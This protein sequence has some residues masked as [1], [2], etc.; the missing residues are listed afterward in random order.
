MQQGNHTEL[1]R[2]SAARA[3]GLRASQRLLAHGVLGLCSRL[4][5]MAQIRNGDA[6]TD[7]M[8]ELMSQRR[9]MLHEL[10]MGIRNAAE[11]SCVAALSDA[12]AESDRG[13]LVMMSTAAARQH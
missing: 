8:S 9:V 10:Q 1:G 12:V 3:V 2:R 13:L 5:R 7:E 11:L 6:I 4:L